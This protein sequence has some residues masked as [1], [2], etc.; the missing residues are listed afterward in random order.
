MSTRKR[1][2]E[3]VKET[4]DE[5][6]R[7]I[8]KGA[9]RAGKIID[10]GVRK[11]EEGVRQADRQAP[12]DPHAR[13]TAGDV[14]DDAAVFIG[15]AG[16]KTLNLADRGIKGVGRALESEPDLKHAIDRGVGVVD[17]VVE[18][19][20][21]IAKKGIRKTEEIIEKEKKRR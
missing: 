9:D 18:K 16:K 6:T 4:V 15:R 1:L 19:G 12:P 14:V 20:I 13:H 11:V 5:A 7:L 17:K 21:E 8:D 10:R 2:S 3:D